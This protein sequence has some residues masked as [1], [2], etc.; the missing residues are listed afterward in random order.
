M[1]KKC[2]CHILFGKLTFLLLLVITQ[3]C[4][5]GQKQVHVR[6]AGSYVSLDLTP[7]QTRLKALDEAK[8]D[9]LV[10]AGVAES[11]SV[12]DFLYT[13]EDNEKFQEI[14]QAFTS[15]ETGGEFMV[16]SI[17]SES[18]SFN[19]FGNM[20]IKVE[21]E[22]TVFIHK[23]EEDPSL[24]IKVDGIDEYYRNGG[25]LVFYVTPSCDGYLK[26]F[27]ITDEVSS[28]LYPYHDDE[29]PYLND[30]PD[31]Q[32]KALQKT[33]FPVHQAFR[34]GYTFEIDNPAKE[35]EFNLLI[36]VFTRENIPFI[37][38]AENVKDIMGWIYSIPMEK[39]KVVQAGFVIKR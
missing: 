26:I 11:I 39:R 22:A 30:K 7:E 20:V 19:E 12:S 13:F 16:Y 1:N 24:G 10:K 31:L 6:A 27:N 37:E 9:A 21:I 14:F 4:I 18:R 23:G 17:I 33:A 5:F 2:R 15:T 34:D 3:L 35:K 28:I 8:R 25:N 36:F 38:N 32:L 29:R